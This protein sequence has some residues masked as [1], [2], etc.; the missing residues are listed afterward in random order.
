MGVI[1]LGSY[2]DQMQ[3][4]S[5]NVQINDDT[6]ADWG[7]YVVTVAKPIA[8]A[9]GPTIFLDGGGTSIV[10]S[11]ITGL[12]AMQVGGASTG[13]LQIQA[14]GTVHFGED[15][16]Q[17]ANGS[18]SLELNASTLGHSIIQ[19][20]GAELDGVL[21]VQ[22]LAGYTPTIG[23]EFHILDTAERRPRGI[24]LS[25][26]TRLGIWSGLGSRLQRFFRL[27]CV[28]YCRVTTIETT[29]L[30]PRIM[31]FGAA[32]SIK[33]FPTARVR[34]ETTTALS[35]ASTITRGAGNFG[36]S[37][38]SGTSHVTLSVPEPPTWSLSLAIFAI[39]VTLSWRRKSRSACV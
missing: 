4:G 32:H 37:A 33:R 28:L 11:A 31:W 23:N 15:Y 34:T 1:D 12:R 10:N 24:R 8:D 35:T 13:N 2:L 6:A 3:S 29:A 19:A 14:S 9:V 5:V 22:L 25:R 26:S 27:H 21:N 18:L 39:S 7:M 38:A 30:T 36:A 17:L 16:V 20:D